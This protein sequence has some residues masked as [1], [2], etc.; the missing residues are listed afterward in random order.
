MNAS[1]CAGRRLLTTHKN[2]TNVLLAIAEHAGHHRTVTLTRLLPYGSARPRRV[3][4][5]PTGAERRSAPQA[6]CR[7]RRAQAIAS[8]RAAG[9]AVGNLGVQWDCSA[10]ALDG[11]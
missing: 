5:H 8:L 7:R 9:A 3:P 10:G 11:H 6:P 4:G 1:R 2:V